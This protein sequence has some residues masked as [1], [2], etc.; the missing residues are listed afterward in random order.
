M[1]DSNKFD[2]ASGEGLAPALPAPAAGARRRGRAWSV[3]WWFALPALLLYGWVVIWPSLQGASY[4]FTDWDGISPT[5]SWVGLENFADILKDSGA[6]G[7]I[8]NTLVIAVVST[9][10]TN[11]I[12]LALALAISSKLWVSNIAKVLFFLPTVLTPLVTAFMWGFVLAPDGALNTLL[13][14]VGLSDWTQIWLGKPTLALASVLVVIHWQTVG[15]AMVVYLAGIAGLPS[16]V[17]EAAEV[18]GA[19]PWRRFWSIKLPLLAPATTITLVLS[20]IGGLKV[21]DQ[22]MALTGGGPGYATETLSTVI[23]K[24]ALVFGQFGYSAALALVLT[25]FVAAISIPLYGGLSRRE[26]S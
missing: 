9:V 12:G 13:E 4:A 6:R 18:D 3:P 26:L 10:L 7:S 19:G 22:V 25:G 21:F 24:R 5:Y 8:W 11:V 1:S 16:E 15:I 20:V 17:L 2:V 23:Y 14:V